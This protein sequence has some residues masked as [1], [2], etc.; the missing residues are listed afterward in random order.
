MIFKIPPQHTY[1]DWKEED[2]SIQKGLFPKQNL[3]DWCLENGLSPDFRAITNYTPDTCHLPYPRPI[4]ILVKV[5]MDPTIATL[6]K[7][8]WM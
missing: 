3:I 5:I 2:H 4:I 1:W 6:F 7:L 8:T